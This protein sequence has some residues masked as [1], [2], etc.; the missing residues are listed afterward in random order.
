M[1]YTKPIQ[2]L[3]NNYLFEICYQSL[4]VCSLCSSDIIPKGPIY[5]TQIVAVTKQT[6]QIQFNG[7]WRS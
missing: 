2:L 1:F 7:V 3:D 6:T 5:K 4:P